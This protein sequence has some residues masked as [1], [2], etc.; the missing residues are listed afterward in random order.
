MNAALLTIGEEILIGQIVDTNSAWMA[1]ALNR[2]GVKVQQIV[3]ISDS[4]DE[5]KDTVEQLLNQFDVVLATGGIGPTNDDNTKQT[6]CDLFNAKLIVHKQSL[7]HVREIFAKRNMPLT[8]LNA[9]QA[10]VPDCCE[11]LFNPLG[12]APAMWFNRNGKLLI[13]MP[14]VPFEMKG[15]MEQH[16]LPRLSKLAG[17]NHIVHRTIQ[18]FGLPESFLA[19][20]ISDWE[21]SLPSEFSLAYLPSPNAIRLRVSTSGANKELIE[22][23]VQG[24]INTLLDIIPENIFG[25]EDDTV[26]SVLAK[27]LMETGSTLAL[28]ESCTGGTIAHLI[29]QQSGSSTYF[30]GGVV[31]YSNEV[32]INQ[33]GV[34]PEAISEHGAVSQP[35][36]EAMANGVRN[37]LKSDYAIATSG[38]AGPTG[39]TAGKPVGTIWVSVSSAKRTISQQFSFGGDRERIILRSSVS[40]LNML[41]L[42][43]ISD[44]KMS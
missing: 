7:D 8:D 23:K 16:V 20:K 26:E 35:V 37:R 38:I 27:L 40:A 42:M 12:T 24:Y 34:S 19:E 14:G 28:A 41:R 30:I 2:I 32:K 9:R 44:K 33:L 39:A 17:G 43:L 11:V 25:F 4:G 29:T 6:L 13:S 10:E 36:V 3:S 21:S 22:Q 1:S 18:T 5:I 15:I 31:A